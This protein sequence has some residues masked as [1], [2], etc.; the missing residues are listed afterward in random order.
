MN[1]ERILITVKTYPVLS[2]KYAEL[3]C[4]AGVNEEGEW[5]RLYPIPFRQL[6]SEAQYKKYQWIEASIGKHPGSSDDKRP[7][8]YRVDLDTLR[9]EES[10]PTKHNWQLRRECF[11]DKVKTHMDFRELVSLAHGNKLSLAIFK[12]S[13]WIG[14]RKE[15]ESSPDWDT[16]KIEKLEQD[17]RQGD[18]FKNTRMVADDLKLVTKLPYKFFY[19][20]RDLHDQQHRMMIEDWEIGAL[21]WRC[22]RNSNNNEAEAV[23]KV[24]QK[25]WDMFVKDDRIDLHLILG[26][27]L[28]FHRRKAP[29]PFV[30]IGVVPLPRNR[31]RQ[32]SLLE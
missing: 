12:P 15:K 4:T 21:Y 3:V 13:K 1:R 14:F 23:T 25:Y 2:R 10:L 31:A 30:I 24:R 29:N 18:I 22:L 16:G 7:E 27:T 32:P 26:T 9:M 19:V 17:R 5:R 6:R 11:F 20:F 8:T 28:E